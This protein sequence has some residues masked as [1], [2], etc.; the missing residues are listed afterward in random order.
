MQGIVFIIL[1]KKDLITYSE[2]LFVASSE[3]FS[4]KRQK[5]CETMYL[6]ISTPERCLSSKLP[7]RT[8]MRVRKHGLLWHVFWLLFLALTQISVTI[9]VGSRTAFLLPELINPWKTLD[10]GCNEGSNTEGLQNKWF[11]RNSIF[12]FICRWPRNSS[13]VWENTCSSK[14]FFNKRV[15][16]TNTI[17]CINPAAAGASSEAVA[18]AVAAAQCRGLQGGI[19]VAADDSRSTDVLQ[20]LLIRHL[21]NLSTNALP[22]ATAT[23]TSSTAFFLQ[24]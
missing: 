8:Y 7:E 1:P 6:V 2:W 21:P 15:Q 10:W 9:C 12:Y 23:I 20:L 3:I 11:G 14:S 16:Q 19:V 13:Y 18:A 5:R 24:D 22:T 17:L 4:Q